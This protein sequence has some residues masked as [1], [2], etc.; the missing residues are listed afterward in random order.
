MERQEILKLIAAFRPDDEKENKI[1]ER[2]L[3]LLSESRDVT[4][5]DSWPGHITSSAIILDDSFERIL[6]INHKKLGRWLQPGG[7]IE[8]DCSLQEAAMREVYEETGIRS[9]TPLLEGI[10][11]LDIHQI[12]ASVA[13][14]E[15][16]HY[17]V[18]FL[19]VTGN[20]EMP[21]HDP[22]ETLGAEWFSVEKIIADGFDESFL[23][24]VE[25]IRKFKK[26]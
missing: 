13:H 18:R 21:V 26:Y 16:Y 3:S 4:A 25:K 17:D 9:L 23:R 7:H 5:R 24:V 19:Y 10:F 20:G 22:G 11:D 15:H 14:P 1:R 12:P 2:F 6:L 8:D